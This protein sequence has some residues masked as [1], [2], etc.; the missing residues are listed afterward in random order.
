MVTISDRLLSSLRD[1]AC[2]LEAGLLAAVDDS[3]AV[4]ARVSAVSKSAKVLKRPVA[5]ER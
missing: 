5:G 1:P 2:G 3:G 4:M